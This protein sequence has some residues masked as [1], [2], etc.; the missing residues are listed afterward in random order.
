MSNRD[1][2]G[3]TPAHYLCRG[4]FWFLVWTGFGGCVWLSHLDDR[5]STHVKGN[6]IIQ[7][8]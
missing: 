6:T 1:A 3:N 7:T 8:P 2:S 5:P 4:L